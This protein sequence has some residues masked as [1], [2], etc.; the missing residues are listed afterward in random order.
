[1]LADAS[2]LPLRAGTF[3]LVLTLDLLEQRTVNAAEVLAEVWR[4]L[5]PG[6]RLLVRVPAHPWLR[7]PHDAFWGGAHRYRRAEL[8]RLIE[9]SGLV[10]VRLTYTNSL[11]FPL[12]SA[13]RLL[14]RIGLQGGDDLLPVSPFLNR[15][16]FGV[17][18]LEACWLRKFDLPEGL[19]LACLAE[20][21]A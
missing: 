2:R 6:G 14:A 13:S 21:V 20:R 1:M 7:G 3:D 8:A 11:L 9:G 19:S 5:R 17:L 10:I 4:V 15:L 18:A 12:A 16:L